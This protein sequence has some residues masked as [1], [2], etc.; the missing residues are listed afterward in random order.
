MINIG[1]TDHLAVGMG[2]L[3]LGFAKAGEYSCVNAG[4]FTFHRQQAC[5]NIVIMGADG[6]VGRLS[7]DEGRFAFS[8][9]MAE[10]AQI[11]FDNFLKPLVDNYIENERAAFECIGC[12]L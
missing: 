3:D 4:P 5:T 1:N 7:W 6:E 2:E 9:N 12:P 10:S 8:G 11:F